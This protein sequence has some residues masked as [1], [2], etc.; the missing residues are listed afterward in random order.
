M[1]IIISER[2]Q[3]LIKE[4]SLKDSLIDMIKDDG[5]EFVVGL[6][7]GDKNFQKL[8]GIETP[9]EF[10]NLFNDL[11]VVQSKKDPNSTLFRYKKGNNWMIYNRESK[12]FH[13]SYYMIWSFLEKSFGL[14]DSEVQKVIK[15]WLGEVYNL[16]GVT[17][18]KWL[19]L[20]DH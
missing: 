16:R 4:N 1:K 5:W 8:T 6:V 17:P 13:I 12:D 14:D 7:G 20:P 9:S 19:R 10:L 3:K 2:Q 15:E 18:R 11:D